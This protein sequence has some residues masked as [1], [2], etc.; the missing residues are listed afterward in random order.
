MSELAGLIEAVKQGD[1]DSVRLDRRMR[2]P[3]EV[4]I[5]ENET[6]FGAYLPDAGR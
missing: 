6:A 4:L 1:L 3:V 2:R 5:A